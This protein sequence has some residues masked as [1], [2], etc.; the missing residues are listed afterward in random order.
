MLLANIAVAHHIYKHYPDASIL[1]RHPSP[2]EQQILQ[3]A[4]SIREYGYDIDLTTSTSIQV[5]I[6]NVQYN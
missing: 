1:R 6:F 4:E 3:L 5:K 2:N